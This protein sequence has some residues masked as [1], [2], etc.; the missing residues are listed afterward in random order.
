MTLTPEQLT[1]WKHVYETRLGILCGAD[2]PTEQQV[3]IATTE[4]D[5]AL[6]RRRGC[7]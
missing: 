6:N 2:E 1:E 3:E 7:E 4:A 5:E